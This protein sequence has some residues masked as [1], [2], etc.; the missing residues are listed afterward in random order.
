M[1][2]NLWH[3]TKKTWSRVIEKVSTGKEIIQSGFSLKTKAEQ[4][5]SENEERAKTTELS[6]ANP[7]FVEPV[8]DI[9][10][11]KSQYRESM[12]R[13]MQVEQ[14]KVLALLLADKIKNLSND[15]N[16][17]SDMSPEE[18]LIRKNI[19]EKLTTQEVMNSIKLL[20]ENDSF[21]LDNSTSKIFLEFLAGNRI[22]GDRLVPI[23]NYGV[24][25]PMRLRNIADADKND[26]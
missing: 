22:I 13:E 19:I 15:Y 12:S 3:G 7:T 8:E 6:A 9:I 25:E 20:L 23:E 24:Y 21:F 16:R 18:C 4:L 10:D 11:D 1:A 2:G 5:F 26:V 17:E 14:I